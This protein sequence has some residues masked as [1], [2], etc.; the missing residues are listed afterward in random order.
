MAEWH[1]ITSEYPPQ[2]GGVSDY[3]GLVAAGLGA[4]SDGVHVWCPPSDGVPPNSPGVAVHRALGRFALADLRRVGKMLNRFSTPRRL[5]VQW[6]PHG[7]GYQSLNL[8]FCLWLWSRATVNRDNVELM[9]HEPYLAFRDGSW[10][11]SAGALVHRIMTTILL[12]ATRRVW[13]S[14][15]AWEASWRPY[16][17]GRRIRFAW[18]PVPSTVPVIDDP[19]A[20][21]MIRARYAPPG[22]FLLGHFGTYGRHIAEL[23]MASLPMLLRGRHDQTVLLLGRGSEALREKLIDKH[24][25]LAGRV[26]VTGALAAADVSRHLSACDVVIQPFPDGVSSRRTSLMVGLCHGLPI[27]TTLG[28]LTEPFWAESGA[29]ALAPVGDAVAILEATERLLANPVERGRMGSAAKALYQERFDV[30][31]TIAALREVCS[32]SRATYTSD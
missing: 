12:N 10:K 23:L 2:P 20:A 19:V 3:T 32:E 15:P 26:Y 14:I 21:A 13:V 28:H 7:Y 1:L 24:P 8:S 25:D 6:V 11:Q 9:V 31:H 4:A 17:L 18:L 16:T 5:L 22:G 27:V 30:G 29:V